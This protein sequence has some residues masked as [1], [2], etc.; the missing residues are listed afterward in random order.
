[1]AFTAESS[2]QGFLGGA[3]SGFRNHPQILHHLKALVSDDSPVSTNKR[4]GFRMAKWC[5]K[6]I[7]HPY[8][9]CAGCRFGLRSSVRWRLP[10][11]E[12]Q[13][14]GTE[15][16]LE[17]LGAAAGDSESGSFREASAGV[18]VRSDLESP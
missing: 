3:I 9:V 6:R 12:E 4:N 7:S 18:F 16:K 8:A 5:E 13:L 14:R 15:D 1:M 2:L 17:D 11:L 10:A